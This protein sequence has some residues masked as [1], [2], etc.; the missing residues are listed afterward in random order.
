MKSRDINN[1]KIEIADTYICQDLCF[2]IVKLNNYLDELNDS[3]KESNSRQNPILRLLL[4]NLN[5]EFKPKPSVYQGYVLSNDT[6]KLIQVLK[7]NFLKPEGF[8]YE[9][10]QQKDSIY[11]LIIHK[12]NE[13][14]LELNISDIEYIKIKKYD[15]Q[16]FDKN[17]YFT[18][19]DS[20]ILLKVK[21]S[22]MKKIKSL[23]KIGE[24]YVKVNICNN[25]FVISTTYERITSE[26]KLYRNIQNAFLEKMRLE[27]EPLIK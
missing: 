5:S 19:S 9:F 1:F 2:K 20:M 11:G 15:T 14:K 22:A 17:E 21:E 12:T 26:I 27:F 18:P 3:S 13:N 8:T 23:N 24:L 6:L 16:S 25:I 4:L 7:Q 10:I